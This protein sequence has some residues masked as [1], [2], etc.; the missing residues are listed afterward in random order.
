MK[1]A[2]YLQILRRESQHV[3]HAGGR[4]RLA[5]RRIQIISV[6]KIPPACARRYSRQHLSLLEL[7][8]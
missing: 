8:L 2:V 3:N 1:L 7:S 4:E 5:H 6:M